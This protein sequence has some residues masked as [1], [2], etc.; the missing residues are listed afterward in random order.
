MS[1]VR[2]ETIVFIGVMLVIDAVIV[3]AALY[4]PTATTIVCWTIV[5]ASAAF[6]L[7]HLVPVLVRRA[8]RRI[9]RI[10]RRRSLVRHE[11]RHPD[12]RSA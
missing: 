6:V 1:R 8:K 11:S 5:A 7:R 3:A 2:K 9:R 4:A 12:R 10:A